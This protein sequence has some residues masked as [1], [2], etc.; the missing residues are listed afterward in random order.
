MN[1]FKKRAH[2]AVI[3][4]LF[5]TFILTG[6]L[7]APRAEAG[8]IIT[9]NNIV[10]DK[11]SKEISLKVKL[12]IKK[13]ILEYMLVG[14]HG[15]AYESV[16]TIGENLPSELNFALL[17]IGCEPMD[18]NTLLNLQKSDIGYA[19][20]KKRYPKSMLEIEIYKDGKPV[21]KESLIKNRQGKKFDLHWVFT[22]GFFLKNN[23][24]A[25]DQALNYMAIWPDN[26]AVINLFSKQQNPY[27][28][29]FGFEIN[30]EDPKLEPG[31]EFEIKIRRAS[32]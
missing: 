4:V 17:L 15:K 14:E 12:A 13:G 27:R 18:F 8:D 10:L 23:K 30:P 1:C 11:K 19:D 26:S 9:L 28:G 16:F 22:G 3:F 20:L 32:K 29:Q 7:S 21:Q 31:Q 2:L 5:I 24:F 25:S 6:T